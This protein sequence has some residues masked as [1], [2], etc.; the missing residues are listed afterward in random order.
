MAGVMRSYAVGFDGTAAGA[1]GIPFDMERLQREY[2]EG[3][4]TPSKIINFGATDTGQPMSTDCSIEVTPMDSVANADGKQSVDLLACSGHFESPVLNFRAVNLHKPGSARASDVWCVIPT[5]LI[6]PVLVKKLHQGGID[7]VV[8][9]SLAFIQSSDTDK[10]TVVQTVE[11]ATCFMKYTDVISYGFLT[12]F[13]FA[14]VAVK[15]TQK[16]VAPHSKNGANAVAG[17]TGNYVYEFD[18]SA[19]ESKWHPAT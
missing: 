17:G 13:A 12:L 14:F 11:Y 16:C 19:C 9:S 2:T 18:Y 15:I 10:P 4:I 6:S 1:G 7:R 8:I 3:S 5:G